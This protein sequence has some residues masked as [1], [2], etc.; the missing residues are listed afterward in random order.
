M[1]ELA[2][3]LA[4]F[5]KVLKKWGPGMKLRAEL[6][7]PRPPGLANAALDAHPEIMAECAVTFADEATQLDPS[8]VA[9]ALAVYEDDRSGEWF[10][11]WSEAVDRI[12]AT[13]YAKAPAEFANLGTR[14][15]TAR[16]GLLLVKRRFGDVD[17]DATAE[18]RPL[19]LRDLAPSSFPSHVAGPRGVAPTKMNGALPD[20]ASVFAPVFG[21]EK[22]FTEA[23]RAHVIATAGS[24][25]PRRDLVPFVLAG[26]N[27]DEL[28]HLLIAGERPQPRGYSMFFADFAEAVAHAGIPAERFRQIAARLGP[29]A[30]GA[31]LAAWATLVA[32]GADA[33][34]SSLDDRV[35]FAPCNV[36]TTGEQSRPCVDLPAM[37]RAVAPFSKDRLRAIVTRNLERGENWP[38]GW[39]CNP[40]INAYAFVGLLEDDALVARLLEDRTTAH[41][42]ASEQSMD[43]RV[44]VW[45]AWE[46][47]DFAG[48]WVARELFA[49]DAHDWA[50]QTVYVSG[51][52]AGEVPDD[53]DAIL[54][55]GIEEHPGRVGELLP[56]LP[57]PRRE[58]LLA[59][60]FDLV[61][62]GTLRPSRY[63]RL[64]A[65]T[66]S[67]SRME[68][69]SKKKKLGRDVL[70]SA[71]DAVADEPQRLA[72]LDSW[73]GEAIR[74][75]AVKLD[76]D[77]RELMTE[78]LGAARTKEWFA[79]GKHRAAES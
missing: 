79:A 29:G 18:L 19:V 23:L 77:E 63:G 42:V 39:F 44:K 69:F 48:M 49:R 27:D 28:A 46:A 3:R 71:I 14:S 55:C 6:A 30:D 32:G 9:R 47:A 53:V 8:V 59:R 61:V 37:L 57:E 60:A 20:L 24:D 2:T 13:A 43:E 4:T 65:S 78:K 34:P 31:S 38:R 52:V 41:E 73:I 62:E 45:S 21:S 36:R 10:R 76:A 66:L 5:K 75:F 72:A 26:A 22:A 25:M 51:L 67:A 50:M 74:A 33:L 58:A 16:L 17:V 35:D 1:T 70:V 12:V 40:Y 7:L 54:S 56:L 15:D 11:G 68:A 64:I